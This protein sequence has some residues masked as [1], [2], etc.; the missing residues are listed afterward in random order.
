[1]HFPFSIKTYGPALSQSFILPFQKRNVSI[2]NCLSR[3]RAGI[4]RIL[5][6]ASSSSSFP[7]DGAECVLESLSDVDKQVRNGIAPLLSSVEDA[8]EA[9]LLT[10]HKEDFSAGDRAGVPAST[11]ESEVLS[12][13]ANCSAYMKELHTFV[14]RV[15]A[16]YLQVQHYCTFSNYVSSTHKVFFRTLYAATL[17]LRASAPSAPAP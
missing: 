7:T 3:F 15:S 4:E 17:S 14:S 9:I 1:M 13:L 2:V 8:V 5:R 10:L 6:D 11:E 16:D 12:S